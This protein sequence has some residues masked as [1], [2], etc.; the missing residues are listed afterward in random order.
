MGL[1]IHPDQDFEIIDPQKNLYHEKCWREYHKLRRHHGVDPNKA[2]V[3]VN[4][5]ATVIG[6]L[7]PRLG[8]GDVLLCG[9]I[10]GLIPIMWNKCWTSL[11]CAK[12]SRPGGHEHVALMTSRGPLF[13]RDTD[14]N[15]TTAEEIA[16]IALNASAPE[17]GIPQPFRKS[18][19]STRADRSRFH[20]NN[21]ALAPMP[22]ANWP[23]VAIYRECCAARRGASVAPV[24]HARPPP[25]P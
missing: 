18:S 16:G 4:T 21:A 3:R 14:I 11:V 23:T 10:G 5:R 22:A 8:Y 15:T 12:A 6:S 7:M 13:F 24:G 17:Q 19:R 25:P 1:C 9:L 2:R 20:P